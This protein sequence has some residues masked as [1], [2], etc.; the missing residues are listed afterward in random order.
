MDKNLA[1][2][3]NH[4]HNVPPHK[5]R[6]KFFDNLDT[7]PVIENMK[8]CLKISLLRKILRKCKR[9]IKKCLNKIMK[10]I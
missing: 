3:Y 5:N 6:Q 1:F 7:K 4:G 9:I 2:E 10:R 8:D